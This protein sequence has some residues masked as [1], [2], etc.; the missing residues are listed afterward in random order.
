MNHLFAEPQYD[1]KTRL[2]LQVAYVNKFLRGGHDPEAATN[3][4]VYWFY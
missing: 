3:R 2:L 4:A 1:L